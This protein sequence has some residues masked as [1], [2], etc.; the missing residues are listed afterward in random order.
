M[1]EIK[2]MLVLQ[3]L[4]ALL[5]LFNKIFVFKKKTIGWTFGILG[6]IVVTIYFYLQMVLENKLNLWVMIVYDCALFLLMVY[7]YLTTHSNEELRLRKSLMRYNLTFK[8]VVVTLTLLVCSFLVIRATNADTSLM[9]IQLF[10]AVFGL[11]GTLLLAFNTRVSNSFGWSSYFL[12]HCF[13]T[14]LMFNTGSP[15][16]AFCQVI[17]AGVSFFGIRNELKKK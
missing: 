6:T 11:V 13:V 16:I 12:A 4:S 9:V 15:F 5:L 8:I 2:E 10:S 3:I 1:V 7:G 14:Y 17:S